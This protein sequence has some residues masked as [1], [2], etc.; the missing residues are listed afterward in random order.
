MTGI[1][2]H[3]TSDIE[4]AISSVAQQRGSGL[5]VLTDVFT[6]SHRKQRTRVVT[7]DRPMPVRGGSRHLPVNA[8]DGLHMIS[9]RA[10]HSW[11]CQTCCCHP[12]RA[13]GTPITLEGEKW[14]FLAHAQTDAHDPKETSAD[15]LLQ[16]A[17]LSRH[18]SRRA[19]PKLGPKEGE[20]FSIE[21]LVEDDAVEAGA[22][23]H[24]S[25]TAL[26]SAGGQMMKAKC[27]EF[28]TK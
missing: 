12:G 15:H 5:I 25:G 7:D 16:L 18:Y 19:G 10:A 4:R 20:Y 21:L 17:S 26:A 6:I 27:T 13:G 14:T 8:R 9:T 23:V 11:K 28:G 1:S 2:V 22:S 3:E 24:I